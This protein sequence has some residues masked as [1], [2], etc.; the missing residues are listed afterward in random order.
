[1]GTSTATQKLRNKME[2]KDFSGWLGERRRHS[3]SYGNDEQQRQTGKDKL[4]CFDIS[5]LQY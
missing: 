2:V 4:S 1:M 3:R 5:E